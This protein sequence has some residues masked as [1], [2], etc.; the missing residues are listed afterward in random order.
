MVLTKAQILQGV[1]YVEE[2]FIEELNG[3]VKI[4]AL[5][6]GEL[7]NIEA[8]YVI[9]LGKLDINFNNV[10]ELKEDDSKFKELDLQKSG[11]LTLISKKREWEICAKALSVDGDAWTVEDVQNLPSKVIE[12]IVKR[13]DEISRGTV[14]EADNFRNNT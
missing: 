1:K 11:N 6:D 12:K 10:N 14:E 5:S 2:F 13:V 8:N 9:E 4:R 7:V 3:S